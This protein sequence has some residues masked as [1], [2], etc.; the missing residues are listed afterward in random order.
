MADTP[1]TEGPFYPCYTYGADREREYPTKFSFS[2]CSLLESEL[3]GKGIEVGST[4]FVKKGKSVRHFKCT[5]HHTDP[6]EPTY[7]AQ[8]HHS[9]NT[10]V[11]QPKSR[12]V[13]VKSMAACKTIWNDKRATNALQTPPIAPCHKDPPSH[14]GP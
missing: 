1:P 9:I 10:L 11:R 13:K 6:T 8:Q 3:T 12:P 14:P 7:N 4:V 2:G 5:A